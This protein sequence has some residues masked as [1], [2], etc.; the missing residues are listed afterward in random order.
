MK[1]L[2]Q[3][4]VPGGTLFIPTRSAT[5]RFPAG[6]EAPRAARRFI[7]EVLAGWGY[8]RGLVDEAQLVI[9]ELATNAVLHVTC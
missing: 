2:Q 9:S 4:R 7:A 3:R 5:R 1:A 6:V 8:A